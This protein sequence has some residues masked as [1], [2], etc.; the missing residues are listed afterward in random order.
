MK[1]IIIEK[2]AV[3]CLDEDCMREKRK[4]RGNEPE[5]QG[6]KNQQDMKKELPRG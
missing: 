3:Y 1:R 4:R 5:E 2:D 6:R